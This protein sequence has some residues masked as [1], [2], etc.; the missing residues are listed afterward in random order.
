MGKRARFATALAGAIVITVVVAW[1]TFA[2]I[3]AF[4]PDRPAAILV[5]GLGTVVW[6]FALHRLGT[7]LSRNARS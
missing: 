6:A 4:A 3:D 5:F 1:A 7:T 2:A